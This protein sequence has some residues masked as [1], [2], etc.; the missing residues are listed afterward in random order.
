[1]PDVVF[2]K[3]IPTPPSIALMAPDRTSYEVPVMTPV[4]PDIVPL[5]SKT[6]PAV[7]LLAA[8][9]MVPLKTVRAFTV[10]AACNVQTPVPSEE[11]IVRLLKFEAPGLIVCPGLVPLKVTVPELCVKVPALL[12]QLP[13][14]L[15]LEAVPAVRLVPEL[16]VK[17]PFI[18]MVT[19]EP[20]TVRALV[21]D[22]VR[23]LKVCEEDEPLIA[24][25]PVPLKVTVPV[26]GVNVPPLLVQLPAILIL[27]AVPAE[28]LVP[29]PMVRLPFKVMVVVEPP[30]VRALVFDV[31]RLLKVC[32]AAEP[33]IAWAPVPLKVTVSV[34]G[35]NA[36]PLFVQ[37][38]A[39]LIL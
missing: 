4:V 25:A 24:W 11:F 38:P 23:L 2:V 12:V 27:E 21:F 36:P 26:P 34:R 3:A 6:G 8:I 39:I 35:V 17:L 28:R 31:V 5:V 15:I 37:L 33:F 22:V 7:T 10:V 20:P 9:A 16:M 18:F 32:D 29:E 30:T 19:V 13:A 1:M 14:I